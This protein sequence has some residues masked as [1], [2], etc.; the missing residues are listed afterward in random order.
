MPGPSTI[1]SSTTPI[2]GAIIFPLVPNFDIG[3]LTQDD[4]VIME[5]AAT[6]PQ[7][8]LAPTTATVS[9]TLSVHDTVMVPLALMV[10]ATAMVP[11]ASSVNTTATVPQASSVNV[12]TTVLK[13]S[14]AYDTALVP[15]ALPIS[16]TATVPQAS[17]VSATSGVV[18]ECG[19]GSAKPADT[20][21]SMDINATN[22]STLAMT[23]TDEKATAEIYS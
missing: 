19:R 9:S 4:N 12:A 5:N 13:A 18:G 17:S 2:S 16:A 23:E 10:Y 15:L 7:A 8:S 3:N 22:M 6:V 20:S 14:S 11:Q 21:T 1:H